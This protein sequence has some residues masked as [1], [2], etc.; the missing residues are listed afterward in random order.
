[1]SENNPRISIGMPVYNGEKYIEEAID[2]ILSQS[3]T[4][5]ELIISDN[6]STDRTMEICQSYCVQDPRIRYHRN[7]KNLGAAPNYNKAFELSRGEFFKW[8]DYDDLLASNFLAKCIDVLERDPEF[9]LVFPLARVID[10]SGEVLGDYE[11][12]S[13][14]S[15]PDRRIRFRNLVLEP[16]TAF[17]VS[18]LMRSSA[19]KKTAL[20]GSFPASDLV[21][22]AEL[23]FYGRFYELP[24][25]LFFPRYHPEQSAQVIRVE[26]NRVAF[27]DTSNQGKILLPKWQ[28]LFAYLSVIN[29][30]PLRN[31]E[32]L[33]CYIQMVR[34]ALKPDH[35]RALGKDV[36]LAGNQI[37]ARTLTRSGILSREIVTDN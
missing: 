8:A 7:K 32:R 15:M 4:D 20:H 11:Y 10:Q 25:P 34:W 2:S 9:V 31:Y 28:Y 36:L 24:E 23:T 19:V 26:R 3:Y 33:Y 22:L 18:G 30:G 27:F 29:N 35:F 1:M 21:F 17:Q 5:F 12:K 37:L 14:T 16:D 6:A 13:D